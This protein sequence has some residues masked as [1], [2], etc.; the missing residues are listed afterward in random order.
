[1][2]ALIFIQLLSFSDLK[3]DMKM[4]LSV[5]YILIYFTIEK[6]TSLS[7]TSSKLP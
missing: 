4:L 2:F 5:K 7:E 1:M 6:D 3:T